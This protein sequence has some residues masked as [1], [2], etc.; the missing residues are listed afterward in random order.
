MGLSKSA[1]P[2]QSWKGYK[3]HL[4][5]SDRGFPLTACISAANVHDSQLAK[6]DGTAGDGSVQ[7]HGRRI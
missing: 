2:M 5:G 4:N 7:S 6:N 3:L 1:G